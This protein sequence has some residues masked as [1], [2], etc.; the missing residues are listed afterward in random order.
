MPLRFLEGKQVFKGDGDLEAVFGKHSLAGLIFVDSEKVQVASLVL[1]K[2]IQ[3]VVL[4][5]PDS[6]SQLI[7][8]L[9]PLWE[10]LLSNGKGLITEGV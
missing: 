6:L 2:E 8:Q 3:I 4:P 9:N 7:G 5:W 1:G 10:G